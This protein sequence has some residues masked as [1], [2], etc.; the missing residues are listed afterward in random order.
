MFINTS[1]F[2]LV[3]IV[4]RQCTHTV[5]SLA[6]GS[7]KILVH[8]RAII[9]SPCNKINILLFIFIF[10]YTVVKPVIAS[11]EKVRNQPRIK[12]EIDPFSTMKG[13]LRSVKEFKIS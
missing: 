3:D 5:F 1:L 6:C 8:T 7:G 13:E 11:F 4:A 9:T 2:R 10:Y 12:I